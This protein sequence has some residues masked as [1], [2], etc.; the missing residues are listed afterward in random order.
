VLCSAGALSRVAVRARAEVIDALQR[1]TLPGGAHFVRAG[2]E[3]APAAAV[4][5]WVHELEQQYAGWST[6]VEHYG[7]RPTFVARKAPG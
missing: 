2:R 4:P 3:V 5:A 1:A 7:D 6:G